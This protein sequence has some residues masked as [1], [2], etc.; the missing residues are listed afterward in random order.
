M[1]VTLTIR[2]VLNNIPLISRRIHDMM[3][4]TEFAHGQWLRPRFAEWL[5][6]Q[7]RRLAKFLPVV[8]HIKTAW[9]FFAGFFQYHHDVP[10]VSFSVLCLCLRLSYDHHT[11]APEQS[12]NSPQQWY[13]DAPQNFAHHHYLPQS[14]LT[15]SVATQ[16]H[17]LPTSHPLYHYTLTPASL[18]SFGGMSQ[19]WAS[20][21]QPRAMGAF[22][23]AHRGEQY[24]ELMQPM[25]N[26]VLVRSRTL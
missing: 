1:Q 20:V 26:G 9:H 10:S 19:T 16:P 13:T 21:P 22:Q 24:A 23:P 2:H 3:Y 6:H 7:P 4:H 18:N 8:G 5:R 12:P 15:H 25:Y 17:A 11:M 14:T